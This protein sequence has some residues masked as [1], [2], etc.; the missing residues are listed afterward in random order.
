M[1]RQLLYLGGV[2]RKRRAKTKTPT[3]RKG[4]LM[5]SIPT[6]SS[7]EKTERAD[8]IAVVLAVMAAVA[9]LIAGMLL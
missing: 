4:D 7:A 2:R 6:L 1:A 5:N 8:R 9:V 3:P